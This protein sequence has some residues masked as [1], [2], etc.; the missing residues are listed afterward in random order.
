MA[1]FTNKR[2]RDLPLLTKVYQIDADKRS[3]IV[4]LLRMQG[5]PGLAGMLKTWAS[6]VP[7]RVDVAVSVGQ[8]EAPE[9][10]VV[11]DADPDT[12]P[13]LGLLGF[14]GDD[15]TSACRLA[16]RMM[17]DLATEGLVRWGDI[18]ELQARPTY[19]ETYH[20]PAGM[21]NPPSGDVMIEPSTLRHI[22][23][24]QANTSFLAA[25]IT[26]ALHVL[27]RQAQKGDPGL[28]TCLECKSVFLVQRAGHDY[29][30]HR[31]RHRHAGRE[32][33]KDKFSK[34]SVGT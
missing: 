30:S 21:D 25:E 5:H 11:Y 14:F 10:Q 23:W 27:L 26:R 34:F 13:A 8:G 31:C 7:L 24:A 15:L 12:I 1:L 33:Y 4:A 9:S 17:R 22:P 19:K 20:L 6:G 16:Q 29:C 28:A 2:D 32:R 3:E 18:Q